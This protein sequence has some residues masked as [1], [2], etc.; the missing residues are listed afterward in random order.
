MKIYFVRHAQSTANI[1]ANVLKTATNMSIGLS[2]VG[3]EQA[4]ETGLFLSDH[5]SPG[6]S[7][8]VWNS[9]YNRT[10]QT[11]NAIK[12]SLEKAKLKFSEEESIYIAERQFGLVD[13]VADYHKNY[14]YEAKHWQMHKEHSHDYFARPPL[15]ESGFDMCLRLDFFLKHVLGAERTIENHIVVSHGAAIRGLLMMNQKWTYEKFNKPNPFNASVTLVKDNNLEGC[16]F[17]PSKATV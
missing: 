12:D 2:D 10:R 1:D 3:V 15:G 4:N 6:D 11:A 13:D 7:I 17:V 14:P 16:I 5:F 8:K 9:P